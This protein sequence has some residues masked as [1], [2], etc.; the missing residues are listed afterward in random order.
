MRKYVCEANKDNKE[1]GHY[2]MYYAVD[3]RIFK[4]Q[5]EN[6]VKEKV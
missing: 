3:T 2:H 4:L 5:A 6:N 1:G